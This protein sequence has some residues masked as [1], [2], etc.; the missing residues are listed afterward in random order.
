[1]LLSK[2][3]N[4]DPHERTKEQFKQFLEEESVPMRRAFN[5]FVQRM[6]DD[7]TDAQIRSWIENKDLQGF[8]KHAADYVDEMSDVLPKSFVRAAN[9]EIADLSQP[10]KFGTGKLAIKFD[11][12]AS[13][14]ADFMESNRLRFIKDFTAA[15]K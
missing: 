11:P 14:A 2:A 10:G 1:M 8:L 15:Q 5:Q 12:G 3:N 7:V 13:N 9:R 4:D 6:L